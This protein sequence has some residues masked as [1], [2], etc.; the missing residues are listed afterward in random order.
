M[1]RELYLDFGLVL[2]IVRNSHL[3]GVTPED[4][5]EAFNTDIGLPKTLSK[6]D[7]VSFIYYC[8]INRALTI[9]RTLC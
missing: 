4:N 1:T 8:L 7:L 3:P 5:S 2:S 6:V 9:G